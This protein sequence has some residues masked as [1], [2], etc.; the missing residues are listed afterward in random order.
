MGL[1]PAGGGCKEM[2]IRLGD[3]KRAFELIGYAKVSGSA[4]QAREMGFLREADGITMNRER[5]LADAKAAALALVPGWAPGMA[6]QDIAVHGAAGHALLSMG[7]KL[8]VEGGWDPFKVRRKQ[9]ED[10]GA[11]LTGMDDSRTIAAKTW[12]QI[13]E[14]EQ[15]R[16]GCGAGQADHDPSHQG[17]GG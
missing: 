8:A 4:A 5:L 1:I 6:R 16:R 3:A 12:E 7:M 14:Q 13:M 11:I 9:A 15:Q 17:R 10:D 2:L